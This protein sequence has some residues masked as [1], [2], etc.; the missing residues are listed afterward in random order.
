MRVRGNTS[1]PPKNKP[2]VRQK[3]LKTISKRK[4]KKKA[5]K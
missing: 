3:G 1:S 4:N 5:P 2:T